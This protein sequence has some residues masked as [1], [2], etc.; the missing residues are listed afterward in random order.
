MSKK[1]RNPDLRAEP[2]NL[3]FFLLTNPVSTVLCLQI[4]LWIP[5]K[6]PSITKTAKEVKE[7]KHT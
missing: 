2:E 5:K 4:N 3:N 1:Y 6:N 7:K